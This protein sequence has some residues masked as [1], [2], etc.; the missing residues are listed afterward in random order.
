[1]RVLDKKLIRDFKRLW[2]QSL[3]VSLVLACGVATLILAVGAYRSLDET[4]NAYYERYRFAHLFASVERAPDALSSRIA[5]INGVAGVQTRVTQ[6]ALLDVTGMAEPA[7]GQI[8]SLPDYGVPRLN[9][10]FLRSGR[11]P[12]P[13]RR[14]EVVVSESF[15][16]A[17]GFMAGS[18]LHATIAGNRVAMHITGVALS[19]EF[20]YAVGPG[21]IVPD[22]KRF[23][24]LWM[25]RGE[26]AALSDLEDAFNSVSLSLLPGTNSGAVIEHLDQLL[27]PYGGTGAFDRDDQISHAFLDTELTQLRGMAMVVPPIFLAISAFLINMILA[28]LVA[29]ER[30]QIGL[31]KALGY[32]RWAVVMHYVKLVLVIA[33]V[34]IL[35]GFAVGTW[36]G[37]G[38]TR[39]YAEFYRFPF[40]IFQRSPD[41]YVLA[42]LVSMGAAIAGAL[43]A[44]LAA[45]W[46]PPAVAM[47]PAP[48]PL[49][50]RASA[51]SQMLTGFLSQLT[52]MALRHMTRWPMRAGLTILGTAAAVSLLVTALFSFGSINFMID[53]VFFRT[54]R[55]DVT[56]S[57]SQP[58]G[59]DAVLAARRLPGV[60]AVE[61]FRALQVE[62]SFGPRSRRI[63]VL[64]KSSTSRL[65][66]LLDLDLDPVSLPPSGMV[67]SERVAD[68][69]EVRVGDIVQVKILEEGAQIHNVAVTG[70]I[71]SYLG[72]GA[73]MDIDAL[74]NLSRVGPRRSGVYA[75]F[76]P[77]QAE[78]IF[79]AIKSM[80][81]AA[82]IALQSVSLQK[83]RDTIEENISIM[84]SIYVV[85]AGIIAF[86]VVYNSARI[87]LS[88]RGRE[89]ASLRVLGFT[90]RE[91]SSVLV[92]ELVLIVLIAQPLGWGLGYGL[93]W[94]VV[95]GFQSDLFRIPFIVEPSA[96]GWSSVA[97]L[98]AAAISALIVVRRV[99]SL[100]MIQVLK[101]RE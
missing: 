39:L 62:M 40:L 9:L 1:M 83:F 43:K 80:P 84:T 70:I 88:E 10:L 86:G 63:S 73:Y 12:E 13:G 78:D 34:G 37:N 42:A 28:R 90:R 19:P 22:D 85:L 24:V 94:L 47:Q 3:A 51:V 20:I 61:P 93:S 31:L 58:L 27:A 46:L 17:H 41:I 26:L 33:L 30:E 76:D 101:T 38:L 71:Q 21:D 82:S 52:V 50:R 65:S 100:D 35:I 92:T 32:G 79:A 4:R 89:L 77:A 11:L 98:S 36:L 29:L 75:E 99:R 97:V 16:S 69:I 68:Q 15:A 53:T 23:A 5:A 72:L 60:M 57:F 49:Y 8:F 56:I 96:F 48:P 55:Q 44:V 81:A 25:R 2:A 64:G 91:V 45:T 6:F 66:R 67:L 95:L 7:T 18:E 59:P 74:D 14:G 54:D 87:Q